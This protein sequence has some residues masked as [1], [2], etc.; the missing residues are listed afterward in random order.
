MPVERHAVNHL[1][2]QKQ[3]CEATRRRFTRLTKRGTDIKHGAQ[4][5][6]LSL[7]HHTLHSEVLESNQRIRSRVERHGNR[8]SRIQSPKRRRNQ[9]LLRDHLRLQTRSPLLPRKPQLGPRCRRFDIL[10]QQHRRRLSRRAHQ[11]RLVSNPGLPLT[12]AIALTLAQLLSFTV[13]AALSLAVSD[14]LSC[15][16]P[17]SI[18][19]RRLQWGPRQS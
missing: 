19:A 8:S 3:T 12:L 15:S 1:C 16:L 10:G 5:P 4:M 13:A 14:S 2:D 18:E 7:S 17:A 11:R 6:S 9:L